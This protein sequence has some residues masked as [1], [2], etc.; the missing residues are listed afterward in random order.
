M[1]SD[2]DA[3]PE[4]AEATEAEATQTAAYAKAA[5]EDG[6]EVL[7]R[8]SRRMVTFPGPIGTGIEVEVFF[9]ES[10]IAKKKPTLTGG[11]KKT[12]EFCIT[13][14]YPDGSSLTS[15]YPAPCPRHGS[16]MGPDM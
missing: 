16:M 14:T 3:F 4:D 8:T 9:R 13:T 12:C 11:A 5:P 15:C 1:A 2:P 7:E 10:V 6:D